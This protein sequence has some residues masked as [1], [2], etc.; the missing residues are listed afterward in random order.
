M[1]KPEWRGDAVDEHRHYQHPIDPAEQDLRWLDES[2]VDRHSRGD[3]RINPT[4]QHA[5]G[6]QLGRDG[7][8]EQGPGPGS[9]IADRIGIDAEAELGHRLVEEGVV[10]VRYIQYDELGREIGHEVASLSQCAVN[11]VHSSW[12]R[13]TSADER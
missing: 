1:W 9:E 2:V 4:V 12:I 7:I 6:Q 10:V 11:P 3:R 5:L 8:D 13:V